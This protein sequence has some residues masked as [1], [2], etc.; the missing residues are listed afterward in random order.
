VFFKEAH[1]A[2]M[3]VCVYLPPE[4]EANSAGYWHQTEHKLLLTKKV[5]YMEAEDCMIGHNNLYPLLN[6][7]SQIFTAI[8]TFSNWGTIKHGVSKDEF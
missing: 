2:T 8:L 4:H 3:P 7:T 5:S 6:V 1:T